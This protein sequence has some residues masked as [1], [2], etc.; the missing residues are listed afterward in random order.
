MEKEEAFVL[1]LSPNNIPLA[2][3]KPQTLYTPSKE[4][5]SV[6]LVAHFNNNNISPT[7]HFPILSSYAWSHNPLTT[8]KLICNL[9]DCSNDLGKSDEEAFY[10]A[11]FWLHQNHPKTLACN[12]ASIAG[13]FS[14][15]VALMHD[16]VEI[17]YRLLQGQDVRR[18]REK[19]KAAA[20]GNHNNNSISRRRDGPRNC[21]SWGHKNSGGDGDGC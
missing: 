19:E 3:P 6:F 9:R 1:S 15:S 2:D 4:E 8:L 10:A 14:Q 11:A 17:L 5:D 18:R 7:L 13:E 20:G 16:L 12:V 21:H